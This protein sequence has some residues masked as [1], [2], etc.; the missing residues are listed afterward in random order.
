[1]KRVSGFLWVMGILVFLGNFTVGCTHPLLFEPEANITQEIQEEGPEEFS[2]RGTS[3]FLSVKVWVN[4]KVLNYTDQ[5][6]VF[7]SHTE[8]TLVPLNQTLR[9]CGFTVTWNQSNQQATCVRGDYTLIFTYNSWNLTVKKKVWWG[10]ETK[11]YTLGSPVQMVNNR[12]MVPVHALSDYT[13]YKYAFWD[14][15]SRAVNIRYWDEP[16]I[17]L[18]WIG[19]S[20]TWWNDYLAWETGVWNRYYD[21]NKPTVIYIHGWQNG[22]VGKKYIPDLRLTTP[23]GVDEFTQNY[24]LS[25]GYNVGIFLPTWKMLSTKYFLIATKRNEFE[26]CVVVSCTF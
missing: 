22:S 15:T 2:A 10:T 24:W 8:R 20:G 7:D 21:P 16:F 12:L 5:G 6:E 4:G 9:R 17:G 3:S 25:R 14:K 13:P 26:E 19:N 23:N 18:V 11:T 1:M